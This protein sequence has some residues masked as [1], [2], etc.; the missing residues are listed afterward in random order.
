MLAITVVGRPFARGL[1]F[2]VRAADRQGLM[3]TLA[4]AGVRRPSEQPIDIEV[5]PPAGG[6][7]AGRLY[8]TIGRPRRMVLL[9]PGFHPAGIDQPR[10]VKLARELAASGVAVVTPDLP[11]LSRFEIAPTTTDRIEAAAVWLS[12]RANRPEAAAGDGRIGLIGFSFSGGFSVVA[13]GRASLRDRVAYVLSV[14]GHDDLT[15][16]VRYLCLGTEARPSRQLR[17]S[18]AA[19]D[20]GSADQI[21]ARRPNDDGVAVL[22]LGVADRVVPR[23]QVDALRAAVRQWLEASARERDGGTPAASGGAARRPAAPGLPEPAATLLR[24]VQDRDVVHLGA[25]LLPHAR[26]YVSDPGLSPSKS[27]KPAAPLFLLHGAED[28]LIPSL[29]AEY[30]ADQVRGQMPVRLLM[31]RAIARPGGE[32]APPVGELLRLAGFWGDLLN[33]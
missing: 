22:L 9:V 20:S 8:A 3:R 17:L 2:V 14:G 11:E 5:P 10:L 31:T 15:R 21:L 32:A 25:R 13:A 23:Q 7:I 29:E 24:Y 4:D 16:V 1:S 30:L 27:P 28:D 26:A 12:R 33:R 18:N 19:S 6:T